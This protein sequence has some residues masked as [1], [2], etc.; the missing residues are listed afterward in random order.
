MKRIG[1]A[2]WSGDIKAGKGSIS[3]ESGALNH[4]PYSFNT[5]F[6]EEKGTNPEEL[7]GAAHAA[8]F[9]MALSGELGKA[10]ITAKAITTSSA[11]EIRPQPG[12]GFAITTAHLTVSIE[13]PGADKAKLEAAAKSAEANCPVSKVL[14]A[15]ISMDATYQV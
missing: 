14:K 4:L 7:L 13:A 9:S 15:E 8:C 6:G 5:R 11:I 1:S 3:T 10:G 12:G 2:E